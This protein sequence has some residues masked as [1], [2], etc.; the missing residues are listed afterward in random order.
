LKQ[1]LLHLHQ[2]LADPIAQSAIVPQVTAVKE[3][4]LQNSR[5]RFDDLHSRK[6]TNLYL[7]PSLSDRS[8]NARGAAWRKCMEPKRKRRRSKKEENGTKNRASERRQRRIRP[9]LRPAAFILYQRI[10][11]ASTTSPRLR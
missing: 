8:K 5:N 2:V 1:L 3:P 4:T 6:N 11:R 9:R 7:L 10:L